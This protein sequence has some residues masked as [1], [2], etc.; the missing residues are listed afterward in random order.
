MAHIMGRHFWIVLYGLL[1]R[2][3]PSV[4]W[5]NEW[6]NSCWFSMGY[7]PNGRIDSARWWKHK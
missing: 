5:D 3:P 4:R 2:D 6:G 7:N 1:G